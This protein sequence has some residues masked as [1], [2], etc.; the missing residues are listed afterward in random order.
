[1]TSSTAN[2]SREF[3]CSVTGSGW[4][5]LSSLFERVLTSERALPRRDVTLPVSDDPLRDAVLK[6]PFMCG[7]DV[8]SGA[9]VE[10]GGEFV[11]CKG[12]V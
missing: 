3:V 2:I 1:M 7:C 8:T 12:G 9:G 4:Y 5:E 11:D 6:L 10:S